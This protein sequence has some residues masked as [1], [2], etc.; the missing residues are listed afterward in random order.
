[1]KRFG[2]TLGADCLQFGI[3]VFYVFVAT[4]WVVV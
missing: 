4:S 1:M 2:H 3:V